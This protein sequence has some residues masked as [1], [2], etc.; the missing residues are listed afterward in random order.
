MQQIWEHSQGTGSPPAASSFRLQVWPVQHLPDRCNL[1]PPRTSGS[2]EGQGWAQPVSMWEGEKVK[3][4]GCSRWVHWH[5]SAWRGCWAGHPS[6]CAGV[7]ACKST[8][9]DQSCLVGYRSTL[10]FWA[11]FSKWRNFVIKAFSQHIFY[12]DHSKEYLVAKI[13]GSHLEGNMIFGK[14]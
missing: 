7:A 4:G 5:W 8:D 2:R 3:G 1:H 12:I 10:R 14:L 11:L 13:V 9:K 6:S